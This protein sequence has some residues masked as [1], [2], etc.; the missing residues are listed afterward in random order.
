MIPSSMTESCMMTLLLI[1]SIGRVYLLFRFRAN[2]PHPRADMVLCA[3]LCLS[4]GVQVVYHHHLSGLPASGCMTI[5]QYQHSRG[6][7]LTSRYLAVTIIEY[8]NGVCCV[9]YLA[10]RSACVSLKKEGIGCG[11]PWRDHRPNHV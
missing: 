8:S 11:V 10:D 6:I 3:S 2:W 4:F 1:M 5:R 7:K 9:K